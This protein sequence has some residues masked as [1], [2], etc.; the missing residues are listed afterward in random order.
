M[1]GLLLLLNQLI[2]KFS[3]SVHDILDEVFPAIAGRILS[4]IPRDAFPSGPGTNTEVCKPCLHICFFNFGFICLFIYIFLQTY[5][6]FVV[7]SINTVKCLKLKLDFS[8]FNCFTL[9]VT[10]DG[11]LEFR[12]TIC[13]F[14]F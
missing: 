4:V 14:M 10:Y 3:T 1:V 13:K 12:S 2:C 11:L 6:V 5:Y 9:E 7:N 8:Y